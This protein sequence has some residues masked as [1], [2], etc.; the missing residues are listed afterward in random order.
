MLASCACWGCETDQMAHSSPQRYAMKAVFKLE[1]PVLKRHF[2]LA[3]NS[4]QLFSGRFAE[5]H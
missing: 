1:L 3:F 5:I 4:V 2:G